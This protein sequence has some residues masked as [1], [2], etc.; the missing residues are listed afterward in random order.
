M[1]RRLQLEEFDFASKP[2]A[3]VPAP[4]QLAAEVEAQ[5]E[6]GLAAFDQGY[7]AGWDDAVA[8]QDAEITK[9]RGDLGRNLQALSFTYHEARAHLLGALEP[10]L[11]DMTGKVLPAIARQSLGA[12]VLDA[13]RPMAEALSEAPVEVVLHPASR[14]TVEAML[15]RGAAPPF[16]ITEEPSLGEGQ[17]YLRLGRT[18]RQ[19]DLD[20]V[21][22][23]IEAA[24]AAFFQPPAEETADG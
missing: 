14:G 18:E 19:V 24:I 13:L 11:T 10:L 23:A 1:S 9:L 8:A 2:A 6:A 17:V 22:T 4:D 20:G 7:A 15:T 3:P 12:V 21:V 5:T 16:R